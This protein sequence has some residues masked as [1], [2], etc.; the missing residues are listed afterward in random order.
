M[1]FEDELNALIY[2]HL[3]EHS[4]GRHLLQAL[5]E[6]DFARD[7]IAP[8]DGIQK[9]SFFEA[10]NNRGLEQLLQIFQVLYAKAATTLP[11]E[12]EDL[13]NLISIDGSMPSFPCTGPIIG[14]APK[15]PR[16]IL[17]LI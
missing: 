17:A 2:F 5:E 7:I 9:S 14:T 3:E 6:D 12:Y 10:I 4:S 15:K 11:K 16:F 13:G 1:T 8:K